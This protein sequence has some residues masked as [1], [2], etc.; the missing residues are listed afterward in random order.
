MSFTFV[1]MLCCG[2]LRVEKA[3]V[4]RTIT[5]QT[6][7]YTILRYLLGVEKNKKELR[8]RKDQIR[9]ERRNMCRGQLTA[10]GRDV[11]VSSVPKGWICGSPENRA[12]SLPEAWILA[13]RV[14]RQKLKHGVGPHMGSRET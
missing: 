6:D 1:D 8:W 4:L 2:G 13:V 7:H 9:A 3:M 11:R 12:R 10:Q 14:L 5:H